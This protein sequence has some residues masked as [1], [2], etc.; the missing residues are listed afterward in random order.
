MRATRDALSGTVAGPRARAPGEAVLRVGGL[1]PLTSID[2]PGLLSAVVWVQGCPWRCVYCHNPHLQSRD[3]AAER[4]GRGWRETA[5]WLERRFG[6]VDAVVFSGGEPTMDAGLR[7]AMAQVRALGFAVGLHTGGIYPRRLAEVLPLTDWVGLDIKAPLSRPDVLDRVVGLR[8][9]AARVAESLDLVLRSGVKYECRTTAHPGLLGE[10][11]LLTLAH[12]L[13]GRG[14]RNY[15]VQVA[16]PV[17]AASPPLAAAGPG[18]PSRETLA[19]LA[20][21][22]P[23]FTLRA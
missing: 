3:A 16:R 9:D 2:F 19:Q 17:A 20:T 8:A 1:T 11:E 12:E 21:L 5:A 18:Y 14:V 6:L 15:A 4:P 22:F 23:S 10:P 7:A 13:A